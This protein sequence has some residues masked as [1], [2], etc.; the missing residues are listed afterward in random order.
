[1]P[2]NK[3]KRERPSGQAKLKAKRSLGQNFLVDPPVTAK[4]IE[5]FDPQ[6]DDAVVE[7]GPGHGALTELLVDE[8]GHFVALEFDRHLAELLR[9]RFAD[10][11]NFT[12]IE[13][14]ALLTDFGR[15]AKQVGRPL[16]LIANLPYNV[17]TAILQ[18]LF[19]S[20]ATFSDCVLMFQREV[21]DRITA[22]PGTKDRGYLSVMTEAY[23]RVERLFDVSPVAFRPVPKVWSAVVRLTPRSDPPLDRDSFRHLVA[24][25][26]RQKRK[27]IVN[28]LKTAIPDAQTLL[29]AS[30][31]APGR[32][33]E[34][35]DRDEWRRLADS[36]AQK[37]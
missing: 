18:R 24:A 14:D 8:V 10:R 22:E 19:E 23:F 32:R 6:P 17:S 28:N 35:L 31:I 9:R 25:S 15:L 36:C 2:A 16:R 33:A 37:V 4:I 21:V 13:G 29:A 30:G 5:A 3:P 11:E 20:A 27:T 7:I 26:F 34:T 12:L 1:M